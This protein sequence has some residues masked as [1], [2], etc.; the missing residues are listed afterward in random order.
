MN[1]K[2]LKM[3]SKAYEISLEINGLSMVL[4]GL[5]NQLDN[6]VSDSLKPEAL[7]NAIFAVRMHMERIAKDLEN[8]DE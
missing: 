3:S 5:S 2:E 6:S 8:I 7:G 4:T 1:D